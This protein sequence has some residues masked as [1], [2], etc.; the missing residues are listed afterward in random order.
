MPTIVFHGDADAT[1]HPRNGEQVIAASVGTAPAARSS[2]RRG[3]SVRDCTRR[4][5]RDATDGRVVAEHW[6]V[7]GAPHAWSGGSAHGSY[8]D[9]RGPDA[10]AEMLRFFGEHPRGA[11]SA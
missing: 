11:G 1:V 10:T 4:V 2:S 6:V 7:H 9:G 8:T 5:H 3:A